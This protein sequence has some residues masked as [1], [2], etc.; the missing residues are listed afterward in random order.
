MTFQTI[1]PESANK[2]PAVESLDAQINI[3]KKQL[4]FLATVLVVFAS[5]C[6]LIF[7]KLGA[8]P[9][10]NP[11]E[12]LYAEPAREML[13]TGEYITTFLNY[14][15]RF[16]KPPLVIWAMAAGYHLFGVTE[17]AARYF[18]AACGAI[19]VAATYLFTRAQIAITAGEKSPP[20]T[21][22]NYAQHSP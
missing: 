22:R 19:L 13:E 12:A 2:P 21:A 14:A 3:R 18:G 17:F 20:E 8:F 4:V 16:T 9:L 6:L 11:D 10:F 1:T 7:Y 15:V 5:A